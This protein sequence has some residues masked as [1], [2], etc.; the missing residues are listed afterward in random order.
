MKDHGTRICDV[1]PLRTTLPRT[2]PHTPWGRNRKLSGGHPPAPNRLSEGGK[3][4]VKD[5]FYFLETISIMGTLKNL[6]IRGA[7]EN[8]LKQV[9]LIEEKVFPSFWTYNNLMKELKANFAVFAVAEVKGQIVGYATAWNISGEAQLNRIAVTP[10]C[11]RKGI[12]VRLLDHVTARLR[13]AG[14]EKILLEVREKSEEARLFYQKEG[15]LQTG[16]RKNYYTDD[17][18]VLMEKTLI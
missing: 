6:S 14:A 17:N 1:F 10:D 9:S 4:F 12:G 11:R 3:F 5:F 13:E 2:A 15:F 18:A 8:D 7:V 16:L